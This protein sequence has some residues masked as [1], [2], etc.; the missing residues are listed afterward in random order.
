[1]IVYIS[2]YVMMITMMIIILMMMMINDVRLFV[3]RPSQED[4]HVKC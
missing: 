4:R 2:M 1:M 3:L